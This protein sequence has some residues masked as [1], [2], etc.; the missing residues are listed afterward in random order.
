MSSE[1][2]INEDQY[3]GKQELNRWK[4][5]IT[6]DGYDRLVKSFINTYG[7]ILDNT[8]VDSLIVTEGSSADKVDIDAGALLD[9]NMKIGI[10]DTLLP[11]AV[12]FPSDGSSYFIFAEHVFSNQEEGTIDITTSGTM[13]G[14][15][16]KFLEVLRGQSTNPVKIKFLN[17]AANF[18]EYEVNEVTDDLNAVIQGATF[19]AEL[20]LTYK[21]I[22]TFTPGVAIPAANK[23]I[24]Q[25]DSIQFGFVASLGAL[26]SIQIPLAKVAVIAAA[27]VLQE[28]LRN[29]NSLTLLLTDRTLELSNVAVLN[30]VQTFTAFHNFHSIGFDVRQLQAT[31]DGGTEI[32]ELNGEGV[33]HFLDPTG[34]AVVDPFD[35]VADIDGTV[36][37]KVLFIHFPVQMIIQNSVGTSGI[38]FPDNSDPLIT[39]MAGDILMVVQDEVLATSDLWYVLGL[40]SSTQDARIDKDQVWTAAQAHTKT[41]SVDRGGVLNMSTTAG[42][43][44]GAI[45]P[46][47]GIGNV[48]GISD[49]GGVGDLEVILQIGAHSPFLW[50]T[51]SDNVTIKHNISVDA[52]DFATGFRP[53]YNE[54]LTDVTIKIG[55][56]VLFVYYLARWNIVNIWRKTDNVDPLAGELLPVAG[57]DYD[58]LVPPSTDTVGPIFQTI[59]NQLCALTMTNQFSF[60][61]KKTAAQGDS[62]PFLVASIAHVI[63]F[64]DDFTDS[65]DLADG[66]ND[67]YTDTYVVPNDDLTQRWI[68]EQ[69]TVTNES[70]TA[71]T[72][73]TIDIFNKTTA[74]VIVSV[75]LGT[76]SGSG[77]KKT[78]DSLFTGLLNLL[79]DVEIQFRVT[80]DTGVFSVDAGGKVSNSF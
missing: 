60:K 6:T 58:C 64:D 55:D 30:L 48:L 35:E 11:D 2:K 70:A 20:N 45:S 71:L 17:S 78:L 59:I 27:F 1:L 57:L 41:L 7:V 9:E 26:T 28:D 56:I 65:E 43:S 73:L 18:G 72:N 67:W 13:S 63:T 47:I 51:F 22:G 37:G 25:Y 29:D 32:I 54:N 16:T 10:Q 44:H 19:V 68:I 77:T 61:A 36:D 42:G 24:Y 49:S 69:L 74:G 21:I 75:N 23:D 76:V 46:T 62:A 79:I 50:A 39:V 12:T 34:I 53:I 52:G 33:V 8:F 31:Y 14:T 40:Y 5:F 3:L 15:A 38:V 66:G 80:S 4:R